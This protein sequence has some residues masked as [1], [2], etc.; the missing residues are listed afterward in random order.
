VSDSFA[1]AS[2]VVMAALLGGVV[3]SLLLGSPI[4][5]LG[6]TT[7][8]FRGFHL[9]VNLGIVVGITVVATRLL[10][11]AVIGIAG[12]SLGLSLV[13]Q[14]GAVVL[15][16]LGGLYDDL[17]SEP[18]HGVL[19]QVSSL[20]RGKAAPGVVKLVLAVAAGVVAVAADGGDGIDYL[21]G[22]PVIAGFANLGNLLDVRPGRS[23]KFFLPVAVAVGALGWPDQEMLLTAVAFGAALAVLPAD[24][25]ERAM[26][27]DAGAY[28][29]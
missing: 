16:F 28:V 22:A 18:E 29:L 27:G 3:G 14:L 4:G 19:R 17:Q 10:L 11:V 7:P 13:A 9:P 8:N 2:L 6:P 23:I 15:V 21:L 20:V 25:G 1:A 24:I 5:R 12:G 26:L